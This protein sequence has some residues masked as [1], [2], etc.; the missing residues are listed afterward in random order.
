MK[1]FIKEAIAIRPTNH[2]GDVLR[3]KRPWL[4]THADEFQTFLRGLGTGPRQERA[5]QFIDNVPSLQ[6][7][8]TQAHHHE[9]KYLDNVKKVGR[10][11][12]REILDNSTSAVYTHPTQKAYDPVTKETSGVRH[13][14][15]FRRSTA[16]IE[17]GVHGERRL[18]YVSVQP[19]TPSYATN[20][21]KKNQ[22]R[23]PQINRYFD[24]LNR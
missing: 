21:V 10:K 4:Q 9:A 11:K 6:S 18:A 19:N 8:R 15:S 7:W 14:V 17:A 23:A 1:Y 12:A 16:D 22:K 2:L 13:V 3:N 5:T 24:E 20:Q